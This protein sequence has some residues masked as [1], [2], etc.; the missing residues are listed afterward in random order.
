MCRI[1]NTILKSMSTQ[2]AGY[3]RTGL[4]NRC[5]LD[6]LEGQILGRFE[7]WYKVD[8]RTESR[9][10]EGKAFHDLTGTDGSFL[11]TGYYR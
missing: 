9:W 1:I 2:Q 3:E 5:I 8:A 7:E 11:V 10:V 6:G 4:L